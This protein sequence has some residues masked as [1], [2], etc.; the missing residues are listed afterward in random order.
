MWAIL[1][2]HV[3]QVEEAPA[4][5]R[6]A[7]GQRLALNINAM[8]KQ[9][10]SAPLEGT[11][12]ANKPK[13]IVLPDPYGRL[14][15]FEIVESPIM[16]P[17]LAA[18]FPEIKTVYG[19]GIDDP[20]ATLRAD[21][22]P[23]GFHAQVLSPDGSWYI[24]PYSR[25][26]SSHY[27]SY[28]KRDLKQ[29]DPWT[30]LGAH[31]HDEE[32]VAPAG[33]ATAQRSS[34]TQ[35]R[36]Y[37]LV[38]AATG[39]YTA[40]HGG[41]V[42]LGQAAIV[43]AVNRVVG[44]FEV[45]AAIRL[46]LVANNSTVVYTNGATDP[47]TNNS[48]GTMLTENQNN[49]TTVIGSANYD[50]GHVF[51]TASGGVASL[52]SVCI[53]TQ[54]ARGTTGRASPTG[55]PFYIDFVIH[56]MGHQ[57]GAEH[58][59]NS[60]SGSC[61]GNRN[62]ATAYEPGSATTIMGYAGICGADNVQSN[63]DAYFHT[64]SYDQMRAYVELAGG[65]A[66]CGTQTA[67]GNA[68]P[69]VAGPGNFTI[70]TGT[71]F[72]LTATGSDANGADVLTYCWEERALGPAQTLA[73]ADNGSS[74][75]TRSF[76]ATTS[77]TRF[78]PRLA[79][80]LANTTSTSEELPSVA[81][82]SWP[83]R[84][85][86]RDNRAGGG[87][88]NQ[89]DITLVVVNT[90]SAFTVTSPASAVSWIGTS[91][92][93]ITWNV[94]G[95]TGSGINTANVAI[96]FSTDGGLTFP[97]ALLASTPND[98]SQSV[99]IPNTP[100]TNGR[101]RVRAVGNIFYNVNQGGAITV[102]AAPS[103]V[104]FA[105]TGANVIS[106]TTGNGNSNGRIDPGETAI[107]LT[108]PIIN[109]G[110]STATGVN[111]TLVSNTPTVSVTTNASAYPNLASAGGTGSNSTFYV[112]NV[113]P[114]HICGAPISLTMNVT[115]TQGN[116]SFGFSLP[117]GLPGTTTTQTFTYAGA[118]V[119][120]PDNIPAGATATLLVSGLSG[121]ISDLNFRFNG[122]TCNTT[123]GS[124]TVGLDH[125]YI[126][127]LTITLQSPTG[128]TVT[129]MSGTGVGGNNLC[130]TVL[131]D[132]GATSIQGLP[133]ASAP[134]TGT[135]SPASPL[136]AF[137]GLNPNGTWTLRVVD[138]AAQDSGNIRAF[139]LVVSTLSP[140][141]CTPP[142]VTSVCPQITSDPV[143]LTVCATDS[144]SFSVSATGTPTPTFQWRR[145]TVPILGATSA[146]YTIPSTDPSSAGSYDCVVSNSCGSVTSQAAT[147]TVQA[148]CSPADIAFDNGSPLPP[149]GVCGETNN[150]VTEADYNL[151][152]AQYF[153]AG[154]VCD[155]ANDDG[156]PLPPFGIFDTN[157]GTTE[158]DY[159]LFFAVYFGGCP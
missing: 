109:N 135:F 52:G 128:T 50:I 129:L 55:D 67:T 80:V 59:F 38:V 79:N 108:V 95:T 115:S 96:E 75:L 78:V 100:T 147:L 117:T 139:G 7:V 121:S 141:T 120:I 150:G 105:G 154:A 148:R 140:T 31:P 144:A 102:T 107:R 114:S 157:N 18:Q 85:T 155:I 98:G 110:A 72:F 131:D 74:P 65:G 41:T 61:S 136:A 36:N 34:G 37:R 19:Q 54:K 97:T 11:P 10:A 84:V 4:W 28:F 125:T 45:E 60:T 137:N 32:I 42:A 152:F 48:G 1:P 12:A 104:S 92:Q 124:T 159:N 22:T 35:L 23:Q 99:T 62:A 93:T 70:P 17:A 39:E 64:V 149:I 46:T 89:A 119:A 20:G 51:S 118:V 146:T 101:V 94:A 82:V 151:F 57:F 88:V 77:P 142:I 21:V 15:A 30:C 90:G 113:S 26:D 143:S 14:R 40:F 2:Q 83:W 106:D 56:E 158:G 9:L 87:G 127:D 25:G 3:K 49:L 63:S 6:P 5:I 24:D 8:A 53:G 13:V 134:F 44:V 33:G 71:P 86:V 73:A 69:T 16:E 47:Y 145:N 132:S 130:N 27:S 116:G 68:I 81:R 138:G 112:L 58:T 66:S 111:A 91:T 76:L 29:T 43:T 156:S 133:A 122:T 126:S 123:I 103:G 153:D